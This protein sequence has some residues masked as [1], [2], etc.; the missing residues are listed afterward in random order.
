MCSCRNSFKDDYLKN[1]YCYLG[2]R[3]EKCGLCYQDV[4]LEIRDLLVAFVS[5]N[6][7]FS[8]SFESG[9]LKDSRN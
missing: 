8:I 3:M 6:L 5:N 1:I 4:L 2:F 9:I 7:W